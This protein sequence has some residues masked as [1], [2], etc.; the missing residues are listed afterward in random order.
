MSSIQLQV[1]ISAGEFTN[2]WTDHLFNLLNLTST[3]TCLDQK[4]FL[5]ICNSLKLGP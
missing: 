5:M 4:E 2:D 3:V 1:K